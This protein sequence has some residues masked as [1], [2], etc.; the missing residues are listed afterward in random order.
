MI[1][2]LPKSNIPPSLDT[3]INCCVCL[4]KQACSSFP[5]VQSHP[6][7]PLLLSTAP[8]SYTYHTTPKNLKLSLP[9]PR[10]CGT[11]SQTSLFISELPW[12]ALGL[13]YSYKTLYYIRPCEISLHL[14]N[15][16]KHH[17]LYTLFPNL[18]TSPLKMHLFY[19]ACGSFILCVSV[20]IFINTSSL[21]Y[22]LVH[23]FNL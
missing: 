1:I 15:W 8:C 10:F 3:M 17:F 11:S 5:S 12:A 7:L 23:I 21:R 14:F 2:K 20:Y 16:D 19:A 4:Q 6:N 9:M 22:F 18:S 13:K